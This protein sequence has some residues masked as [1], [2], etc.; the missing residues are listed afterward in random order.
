MDVVVR[1]FVTYSFCARTIEVVR[2]SLSQV[3][4][5]GKMIM[6]MII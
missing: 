6:W 3:A 5:D 4:D 1:L 2:S